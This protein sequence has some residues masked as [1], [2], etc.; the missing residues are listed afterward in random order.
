MGWCMRR[1]TCSL[2]SVS[3]ARIRSR[4]DFRLT[5]N[6]PWRVRL[7]MKVK[8]RKVKVSGLPSPCRARRSAAYRPNS[9]SRVFSGCNDSTHSSSR[10]RIASQKRRASLLCSK[11]TTT[12]S[13]Y[14]TNNHITRGFAP[15]PARRP[16]VKG[17]VQ[18][19]IGEQRRN[20]RALPRP[21][22]TDRDLPVFQ[23][24]RLEPFL[25]Q[26]DDASI[27]DPVF[28]KADQPFLADRIEEGPNVRIEN[29]VHLVAGDP[30]HES[31]QRIMLAALG[32]KPIREPEEFLL[33]DRAQH[34]GSRPLDDL[35]LQRGHR[36]RTLSAI[37]LWNVPS[38]GRQRPVCPPMDPGVQI[39]EP[40]LEICLV[41]LP[42]QPV[43]PGGGVAL[44][45][46]ERHPQQIDTDVVE[47][48]REPF[49][50][51][52]LGSLPYALQRL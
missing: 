2:S 40:R 15:S 32:P 19:D 30:D 31:I 51:P 13:A 9:M 17:I 45:R 10:A 18:V 8:P 24:A 35:V 23:D 6:L 49:L 42:D 26:A 44:E 48:R 16:E 27:G 37:R 39:R 21:R 12:S 7:Q 14:R 28:D 43:H 1:R 34:R 25:D 5:W 50:L 20:H 52:F 38:P 22:L 47:E 33:V 36:Q 29:P 11:P 4:R 41:V 3:F 46:V